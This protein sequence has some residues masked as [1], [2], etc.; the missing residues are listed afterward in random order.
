MKQPISP[1]NPTGTHDCELRRVGCRGS[2]E[3]WQTFE[4]EKKEFGE[5]KYAFLAEHDPI[6]RYIKQRQDKMY[7]LLNRQAKRNRRRSK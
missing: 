4:A 2:C 7:H 1:C 6:N 3:K 5:T